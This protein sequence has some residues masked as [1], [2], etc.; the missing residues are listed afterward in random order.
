MTKKT[1]Q[2]NPNYF[3]LSGKKTATKKDKKRKSNIT[4]ANP[5]KIKKQFLMKIKE[6]QKRNSGGN[7]GVSSGESSGGS[8]EG[9]R[10]ENSINNSDSSEV[11]EFEDEFNKSLNFLQQLS[12]NNNIENKNKDKNKTLKPKKFLSTEKTQGDTTIH[13]EYPEEIYGG[14]NNISENK[15]KEHHQIVHDEDTANT[16]NIHITSSKLKSEPPYSILKNGNKP[17]YRQWIRETQKIHSHHGGNIHHK[18]AITIENKPS[19]NI[20]ERSKELLRIKQQL[21]KTNILHD[22][23]TKVSNTYSEKTPKIKN[24]KITK[25]I[26]RHL[27]KSGRKVSILIKNRETRKKIQTEKA[28]LNKKSI[29]EVKEYLRS[30]NL[31]KAGTT[32]PNHVLRKLYETSILSGEIN[33]NSSNILLH[34]FINS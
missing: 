30:H 33:N 11:K 13:V 26:K 31:I 8:S 16:Y 10:G 15:L 7:S 22:T 27:G 9:D 28:L 25:T 18:Q 2:F 4:L 23:N 1:I 6:F 29:T 20:S 24:K 3:T 14:V 19:E 17:T 12:K 5:N 21:H 34:N 32:A